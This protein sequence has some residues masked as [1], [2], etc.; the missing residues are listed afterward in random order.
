MYECGQYWKPCAQ[1]EATAVAITA[2]GI[3]KN[4]QYSIPYP[5]GE[6]SM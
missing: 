1:E 2:S 6:S 3:P 4:A 5:Q